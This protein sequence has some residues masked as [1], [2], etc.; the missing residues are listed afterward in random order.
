MTELYVNNFRG[1]RDTF[2]PID[3][4]NFLIGENSTG[5]TSILKLVRVLSDERFWIDFDLNACGFHFGY[6][7]EL[8]D[9][10]FF[11]IGCLINDDLAI[12]IKYENKNGIAV[13]VDYRLINSV[14]DVHVF[15]EIEKVV[16]NYESISKKNE[17]K[18]I[19][20]FRNWINNNPIPN[21]KYRVLPNS[22]VRTHINSGLMVALI[23]SSKDPNLSLNDVENI[24]FT[25]E[26]TRDL[27]WLAPIRAEPK[28]TYDNYKVNFSPDGSHIPFLLKNLLPTP[29][30]NGKERDAFQA[31]LNKFGQDSGLF[32]KIE[33]KVLGDEQTSPLEIRVFFGENDVK[34]SNVGYGV[35]QILPL[36]IE[37]LAK[38]KDMWYA[39]QQ[40]EIH[41]H[42]RGQAAFG[43]LIYDTQKADNKTF[44][45]ETHSDYIVDRF[46]LCVNK[47]KEETSDE[48]QVLFFERTKDGNKVTP[49]KIQ[50]NGKYADEQPQSFQEFF[51]KEQLELIKL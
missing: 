23:F 6:F 49:I 1:F 14:R 2:I 18:N 20:S 28:R 8:C 48:F 17:S 34:I 43:E 7:N 41:L 4:V 33:V 13:P 24:M 15:V 37:V 45:I 5:K 21:E 38:E 26:Y 27:I 44:I 19:I 40:P 10:Y 25:K 32:D 42:P 36:I 22:E 16:F 50:P 46:R 11:E 47:D 31:A 35:S 9:K 39:I 29:Q 30:S 51:I 3:K 12:K